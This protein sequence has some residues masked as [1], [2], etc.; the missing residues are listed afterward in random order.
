MKISAWFIGEVLF[1]FRRPSKNVVLATTTKTLTDS[2][3]VIR[4]QSFNSAKESH[5]TEHDFRPAV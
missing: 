5:E 2:L 1:P 4:S 3:T